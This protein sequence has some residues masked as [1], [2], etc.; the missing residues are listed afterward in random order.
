MSDKYYHIYKI[1]QLLQ[2]IYLREYYKLIMILK[3]NV[4]VM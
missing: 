3:E 4:Y 2:K 1:N